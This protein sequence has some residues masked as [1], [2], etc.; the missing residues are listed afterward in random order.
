MDKPII[1]RGDRLM[2]ISGIYKDSVGVA[3]RAVTAAD[4]LPAGYWYVAFTAVQG[5]QLLVNGKPKPLEYGRDI[6]YWF[7]PTQLQK[8][9]V[10]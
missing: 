9:S 10:K 7:G 8:C 6:G 5:N 3:H 2:I 1:S 4:R